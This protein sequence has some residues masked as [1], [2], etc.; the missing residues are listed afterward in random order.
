MGTVYRETFTKPLPTGAKVSIRKGQRFAQWRDSKGK[1]RTAPLTIG[2]D[3]SERIVCQAGTY[4]AKYRDGSGIVRKVGTRC[5]DK[6][7]AESVLADLERRAELVKAKVLTVAEDAV[8][9]HQGTPLGDHF[10]LYL[11]HLEAEGTSPDHRESVNRCLRRVAAECR[12]TMLADLNRDVFE[13]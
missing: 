6:T 4:T 1:T 9:D 13:G 12:L 11:T 2:K 7:A 8:A 5:R 3:G 10:P